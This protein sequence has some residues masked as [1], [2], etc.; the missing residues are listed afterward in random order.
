[1]TLK[2]VRDAGINVCSGGILGMG[3]SREDR[4]GLLYELA[5]LPV[6]PESVPINRLVP[7]AGTP[8]AEDVKALID[9]LEFVRCVAVARILFPQAHVRLS[10]G[11]ETMSEELQ[12]WCFFAGANSVFYGEKLLT[13]GNPAVQADQALL[14]KLGLK[15]EG[16]AVP[17]AVVSR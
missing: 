13:T 2:T 11:R 14:K 9:P 10:A 8:V 17:A 3:E 15:P 5:Q 12:A 6:A 4:V 16:L 7:I 1:M